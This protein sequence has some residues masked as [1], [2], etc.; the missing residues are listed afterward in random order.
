M[1]FVLTFTNTELHREGQVGTVGARLVPPLHS[2]ADGA[3]ND[4]EVQLKRL[5]PFVSLLEAE[6]LLLALCK[7]QLLETTRICQALVA[8]RR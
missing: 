4:G 3:D 8:R 6:G 1:S 2:S 7:I 5:L